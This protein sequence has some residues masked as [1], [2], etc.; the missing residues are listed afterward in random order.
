MRI[1]VN[2]AAG[3][4]GRILCGIIENTEDLELAARVDYSGADGT[5]ANLAEPIVK[6]ASQ[7]LKVTY[8]LTDA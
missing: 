2:G 5:I 3:H 6:N 8:T 1:I 4:M 7:T